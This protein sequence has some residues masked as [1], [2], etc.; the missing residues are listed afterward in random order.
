MWGEYPK[1]SVHF[2]LLPR[3][4]EYSESR[5]DTLNSTSYYTSYSQYYAMM[6]TF[7]GRVCAFTNTIT[8]PTSVN[9]VLPSTFE[10]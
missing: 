8:L 6:L 1:F 9:A 4:T 2:G 5:I 3:Y 7:T 10:M